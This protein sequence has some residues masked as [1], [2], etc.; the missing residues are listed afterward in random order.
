M[1]TFKQFLLEARKIKDWG[2]GISKP[3]RKLSMK[4]PVKLQQI[5]L[6]HARNLE[7]FEYKSGSD[8]SITY[9][10]PEDNVLNGKYKIMVAKTAPI[11][12]LYILF[13]IIHP[14]THNNIEPGT[15]GFRK[16]Q[17]GKS[18]HKLYEPT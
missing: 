6:L 3:G 4:D 5:L 18:I 9:P 10:M 17:E 1:L 15:F 16:D 2:W 8:S 14:I 11:G 13:N 7:I 12:S